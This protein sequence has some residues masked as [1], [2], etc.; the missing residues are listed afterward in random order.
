M[1]LPSSG[2]VDLGPEVSSPDDPGGV[3]GNLGAPAAVLDSPGPA[4]WR[5]GEVGDH[6]WEQRSKNFVRHEGWLAELD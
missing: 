3:P 5:T 6:N 1:F 4:R 2:S